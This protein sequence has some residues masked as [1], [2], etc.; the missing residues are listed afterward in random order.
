M[1]RNPV[2]DH[3]DIL[4]LFMLFASDGN[5]L[6]VAGVSTRWRVAWGDRP[7]IILIKVAVASA[8]CLKSAKASRCPWTKQASLLAAR[9]GHLDALRYVLAEGCPHDIN[10]CTEAAI[11]EHR[12][13]VGW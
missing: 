12:D 2:I 4:Q 3:V 7:T 11:A 10:A 6:F 13:V 8:S 1:I 5:F 9:G